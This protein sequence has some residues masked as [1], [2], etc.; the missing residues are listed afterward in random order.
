MASKKLGK[1]EILAAFFDEGTY[2]G[3]F[4][5]GA[6]KA[7][8]GCAG[9]QPVYAV[10]QCGEAVCAK[11]LDK[12][13]AVLE[14]AA[15]TGTPVVTFYDCAG[16][17]LE[18]GLDLLAAN[19]KLAGA[20]ANISGVVPQ[21]AVV[22]GVC[23]GS[24][25]LNAVCADLCVMA[26][27]AQ[28]FLTAPFTSDAAGD[29][30]ENAGSAELAAK[31][32]VASIL[33]EDAADAVAKAAQ[34]IALLPS[35]NLA[36]PALFDVQAPKA[37]FPS[38][39]KAADAAAALADEGS[40]VE[41]F[42]GFGKNVYTALAAVNGSAVGIAAT[43]ASGLCHNCVVKLSRFV[44]LC[45]AFSIPVVTVVNTNGFVPSVSDD[46]AGGIR[47]AARLCATYADATTAKVAVVAGKAV[48]PVYTALASADVTIAL[49]G[50]VIAP[51]APETA[52]TILYKDEI[53]AAESIPAATKAKAAEYVKNVCGAE[54]A[55]A[56]GLATMAV[57]ADEVRGAVASALDMTASKRVQR[58][59]KKHGN[60]AL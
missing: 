25:A 19:N 48:G 35:N 57:K 24:A 36:G 38:Q 31:A 6:V 33:A 53:D 44:R 3:L 54:A 37:N 13:A 50:A 12:T 28:L 29:K 60:M 20:I 45:D 59:P 18:E 49:P 42:G 41:L 15:K 43:E 21:V 34:L 10:C 4:A 46:V 56:A 58:L 39:Y 26:K 7:A 5:D 9:G 32:G 1:D 8:Y 2:T 11:E 40:L 17:K 51:V 47:E 55:V 23:G 16:A 52:V 30:V 14:M 27:D 22:L